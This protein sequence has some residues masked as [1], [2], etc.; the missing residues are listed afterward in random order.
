MK[1]EENGGCPLSDQTPYDGCYRD[2]VPGVC[3]LTPA[4]FPIIQAMIAGEWKCETCG[5]GV[6]CNVE[7]NKRVGC[8][9]YVRCELDG[10]AE[11]VNP[12]FACKEWTPK[13]DGDE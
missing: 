11:R 4:D 5:N 1:C 12:A 9:I 6:L 2:M 10:G 7:S 8:P 13:G 3:H